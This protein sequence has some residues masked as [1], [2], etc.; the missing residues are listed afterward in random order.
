MIVK[1]ANSKI[2]NAFVEQTYGSYENISAIESKID[3]IL[4]KAESIHKE[5][6]KEANDIVNRP[7][8]FVHY[9]DIPTKL[10]EGELNQETEVHSQFANYD[11]SLEAN[12]LPALRSKYD[13]VEP[14]PTTKE[15]SEIE[16]TTDSYDN[17]NPED[18]PNLNGLFDNVFG[19]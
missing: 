11:H 12:R 2:L 13:Y 9:V 7:Q 17:I 3:D 19:T 5:R 16:M 18:V 14:E 1:T 15:I 8:D 10:K 4:N 6:V